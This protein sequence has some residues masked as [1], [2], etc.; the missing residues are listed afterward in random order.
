MYRH[1]MTSGLAVLALLFAQPLSA[2]WGDFIGQQVLSGAAQAVGKAVGDAVSGDEEARQADGQGG[3]QSVDAAAGRSYAGS[4][5]QSG[6]TLE[7]ISALPAD[8][9]PLAVQL[10]AD[11]PGALAARPRIAIPS[12]GIAFIQ[13]GDIK[14][15]AAGRGS[16]IA[17]RSVRI[18]VALAGL[19]DADYRMLADEA[20]ADLLRRLQAAGID[21]VGH[22]R[23]VGAAGYDQVARVSGN[24]V[25]DEGHITGRAEQKWTVYGADDAPLVKGMA[26]ETGFAAVAGSQAVLKLV[27][28]GVDLDAVVVQPLLVVD[29]AHMESSGSSMFTSRANASAGLGFT[30]HSHSRVDVNYAQ[31]KGLGNIWGPLSLEQGVYS[32]EPFAVL[33]KVSANDA[34]QSFYQAAMAA[35]WGSM[36]KQSEVYAAE[37]A[38]ARYMGLVRAAYAG[39]NSAIVAQAG[40]AHHAAAGA[41]RSTTVAADKPADTAG[42]GNFF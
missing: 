21:A 4:A 8:I 26:M 12:Y 37:V 9:P 20:Y 3:G 28:V 22:A 27:D 7:Q 11:N 39:F 32:D 18:K 29:F 30:L 10:K 5:M 34:D 24:R 17:Q 6:M 42:E 36:F 13:A 14:G 40:Q 15:Y 33:R 23:M 19:D 1:S 38:K 35:G 41:A 25:S 16:S 31:R 2:G